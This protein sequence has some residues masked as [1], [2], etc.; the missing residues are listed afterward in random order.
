MSVGRKIA[1]KKELYVK[2]PDKYTCDMRIQQY[3]E[4]YGF[5]RVEKRSIQKE[6]DFINELYERY[7]EDNGKTWSDWRDVYKNALEVKKNGD[8]IIWCEGNEYFNP[9]YNHFV[10]LSMQR[11]FSGNHKEAYN[12]LWSKGEK[13]FADHTFITIR[14]VGSDLK[15]SNLIKYHKN[16]DYNTEDWSNKEYFNNN[17]SYLGTN[18]DVLKNGDI[19]FP[20]AANIKACCN[21]LGINYIDE[22]PPYYYQ[23]MKGLIIIKGKWDKEER[24]YNLTFSKPI[25]INDLKSSRGV[26][27]PLAIQLKSGRII[28]IFRGSNM[29]SDNWKTRIEEGTPCHKWFC[30]SDDNGKTFTDPVPWHFDDRE[31]IYSSAS[32]SQIF[33]SIKNGRIYWIGNITDYEAYCNYP[34]YPLNI[35]EIDEGSGLPKKASNTIIDTRDPEKDSDK[36]Q[37]S[38]FSII[39][40]RDTQQIEIYLVKYGQREN[41]TYWAD[42]YRYFV[43][44]SE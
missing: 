27:E 39:Q 9:V 26:D 35:V 17:E 5:K 29:K 1:V 21:I 20:I 33:R 10:S 4:P 14:E 38:N 31:V 13:S 2:A 36:L 42:C 18:I 32:Y 15:K 12:I 25:I 7:S 23:L 44:L 6:S 43:E 16:V 30:Y 11:I 19:I 24:K 3:T 37:L 40:D 34:R 8:E 22:F 28:S 41:Y